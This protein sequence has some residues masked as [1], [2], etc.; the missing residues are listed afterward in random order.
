VPGIR[1]PQ[2]YGAH[3]RSLDGKQRSSSPKKHRWPSW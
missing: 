2:N 1:V 3:F